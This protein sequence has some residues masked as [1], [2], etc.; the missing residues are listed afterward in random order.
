MKEKYAIFKRLI[1]TFV[2]PTVR[3][4]ASHAENPSVPAVFEQ[5]RG[6]LGGFLPTSQSHPDGPGSLRHV[7]V[8]PPAPE[9]AEQFSFYCTVT[10]QSWWKS[11]L[12][13]A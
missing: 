9:R 10:G 1:Q 7:A 4:E 11:G 12:K 5:Q 2:R 8:R 13:A 6:V 3:F